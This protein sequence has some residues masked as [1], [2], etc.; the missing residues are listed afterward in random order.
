[1]KQRIFIGSIWFWGFWSLGSTLDFLRVFPS[2]PLLAVG[3][4]S[5]LAATG[6]IRL[7]SARRQASNAGVHAAQP[8]S[9][10]A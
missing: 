6:I 10:R 8:E 2:W 5:A 4:I 9:N 7:P 1:M 3:A